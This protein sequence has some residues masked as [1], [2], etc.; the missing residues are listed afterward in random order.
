[1]VKTYGNNTGGPGEPGDYIYLMLKTLLKSVIAAVMVATLVLIIAIRIVA[2][3]LPRVV[4]PPVI[5]QEEQFRWDGPNELALRNAD[6]IVRITKSSG[7]AIEGTAR[8]RI[9]LREPGY[10]SEAT[11]H[12]ADMVHIT[13]EEKRVEIISETTTRPDFLE[14]YVDYEFRI[15]PGVDLDIVNDNGNVWIGD[16]AGEV[17]V[18]GRNADI[19]VERPRGAV[20]ASTLNGRIRADFLPDGAVL[21]TVNGNIYAHL[22]GG[23]LEA[24]TTNGAIVL[25]MLGSDPKEGHLR[26]QNGGITVA[27]DNHM[28]LSVDAH[29]EYGSVRSD[30]PVDVTQGM[31]GRQR[32][33]GYVGNDDSPYPPAKLHIET[34]NGNI[35]LTHARRSSRRMDN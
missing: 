24:T 29:T 20:E 31:E 3:G 16:G 1:M 15:P 26:S 12:A 30:L 25:H 11:L 19:V 21:D 22:E 34:L 17:S 5:Q 18:Q 8:I 28:P 32:L 2:P 33:I 23:A 13:K 7:N 10:E 4:G 35:W 27:A 9:Y 14:V 6:G